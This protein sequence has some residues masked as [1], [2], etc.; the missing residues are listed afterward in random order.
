M[1]KHDKIVLVGKIKLDT[2]ELLISK[3]SI[4]S[5]ITHD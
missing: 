5:S 1:K 3:P 2:I 4:D